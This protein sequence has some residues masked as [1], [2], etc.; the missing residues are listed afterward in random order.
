MVRYLAGAACC[1]LV[2][3]QSPKKAPSPKPHTITEELH[4]QVDEGASDEKLIFTLSHHTSRQEKGESDS[5]GRKN[6]FAIEIRPSVW[7]EVKRSGRIV[8]YDSETECLLDGEMVA[9]SGMPGENFMAKVEPLAMDRFQVNGIFLA[10]RF[11]ESGE[12]GETITFNFVAELGK[13]TTVYRKTTKVNPGVW[14]R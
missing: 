3:C 7:T 14:S 10:S 4:I 5:H 12:L 1:L 9:V 13:E 2:G 11:S 8:G 6:V